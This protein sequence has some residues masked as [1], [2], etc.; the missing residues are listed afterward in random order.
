VTESHEHLA[1]RIRDFGALPGRR[2]EQDHFR[3]AYQTGHACWKGSR[4]QIRI[5]ASITVTRCERGR[6]LRGSQTFWN[7]AADFHLVLTIFQNKYSVS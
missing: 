4:S 3:R 5:A 6:R 2:S 7:D 1:R